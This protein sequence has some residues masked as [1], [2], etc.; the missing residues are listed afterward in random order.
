MKLYDDEKKREIEEKLKFKKL[1]EQSVS[2]YQQLQQQFSQQQKI[3]QQ[4][5]EQIQQQQQQL[6]QQ[7]TQLQKLKEELDDQKDGSNKT[8]KRKREIEDPQQQLKRSRKGSGSGSELVASPSPS[9]TPTSLSSSR[10]S[11]SPPYAHS[12][13]VLRHRIS[14]PNSPI[15]ALLNNEKDL[16]MDSSSPL[17]SSAS[18]GSQSALEFDNYCKCLSERCRSTFSRIVSNDGT[19]PVELVGCLKDFVKAVTDK[20]AGEN[21]PGLIKRKSSSNQLVLVEEHNSYQQHWISLLVHALQT[22]EILASSCNICRETIRQIP[23]QISSA[24]ISKNTTAPGLQPEGSLSSTTTVTTTTTAGNT[25]QNS[26]ASAKPDLLYIPHPLCYN[27]RILIRAKD[28]PPGTTT[29]TT[30]TI[31][32]TTPQQPPIGVNTVS[33]SKTEQIAPNTL[34]VPSTELVSE[35]PTL[36]LPQYNR[37]RQVQVLA[38]SFDFMDLLI[39]NMPKYMGYPD[40]VAAVFQL[41]TVLLRELPEHNKPLH[42][43]QMAKF[44]T[45]VASSALQRLFREKNPAFTTAKINVLN[46][47]NMCFRGYYPFSCYTMSHYLSFIINSQY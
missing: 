12:K 19:E 44:T 22:L 2:Q 36:Q 42:S 13:S 15:Y 6:Q 8:G 35:L 27:P 46:F 30:T 14:A 37:R 45:V 10:R 38:S 31:P 16:P 11:P 26:N 40:V 9:S 24:T 39:T 23:E 5:Q 4:N 25:A 41:L 7:Q 3:Q 21:E 18:S 47:L 20:M 1:Y 28:K 17:S 34:P 29:N 33:N 43:K 32:T